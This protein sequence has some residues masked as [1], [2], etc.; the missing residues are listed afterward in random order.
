MTKK[1]F[2]THLALT[3][4]TKKKF[5]DLRKYLGLSSADILID[6]LMEFFSKR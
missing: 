6:K 5:D 4:E 2:S 1:D 3:P